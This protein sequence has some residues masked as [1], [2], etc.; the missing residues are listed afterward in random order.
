MEQSS[1][2]VSI[3]LLPPQK[4]HHFEINKKQ[5]TRI[6]NNASFPLG[7]PLRAALIV[8]VPIC[9]HEILFQEAVNSITYYF[10]LFDFT[11]TACYPRKLASFPGKS[12]HNSRFSSFVRN[13]PG[14]QCTVTSKPPSIT[15]FMT[16]SVQERRKKT[17]TNIALVLVLS[18]TLPFRSCWRSLPESVS[19][20]LAQIRPKV[21]ES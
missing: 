10:S 8:C 19:P 1:F 17:T 9:I 5:H 3:L 13:F 16:T 20:L 4:T 15:T 12:L 7:V 18:L 21:G 14:M 6:S 2:Q 11:E